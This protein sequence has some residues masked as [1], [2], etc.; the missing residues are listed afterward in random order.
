MAATIGAT[1][2]SIFMRLFHIENDPR[3][4]S[5]VFGIGIFGAAFLLSWAAEVA[6]MDI[7]KGLA[8]AILALIAIL[9]EYAVDLYLPGLPPTNLPI[10]LTPRPT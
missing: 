3:L 5:I 4:D 6:Q 8:L 9:P 10:L 1:L 2:P 7:P